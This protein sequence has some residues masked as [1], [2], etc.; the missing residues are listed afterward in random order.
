MKLLGS[1]QDNEIFLFRPKKTK[2]NITELLSSLCFISFCFLLFW[3]TPSKFLVLVSSTCQNARFL[4]WSVHS[5]VQTTW[6]NVNLFP[7]SARLY[8]GKVWDLV[9]TRDHSQ[10]AA[11]VQWS[12]LK[13]REFTKRVIYELQHSTS[14]LENGPCPL[15]CTHTDVAQAF[16]PTCSWAGC[17]SSSQQWT[18]CHFSAL[19][20]HSA[21]KCDVSPHIYSCI[22][23]MENWSPSLVFRIS[24]V[25]EALGGE[26]VIAV[27]IIITAT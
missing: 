8:S 24:S 6:I 19:L 18:K 16:Y 9:S 25:F 14:G 27:V 2:Q 15:L 22:S 3:F 17:P 21:Y 11:W 7:E 12:F 5:D 23:V 10:E 26:A 20:R 1:L 4:Y 13:K